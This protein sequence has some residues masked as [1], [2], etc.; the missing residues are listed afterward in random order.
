MDTAELSA[1][2]SFARRFVRALALGVVHLD[3]RAS[4]DAA[5]A[6]VVCR[7]SAALRGVQFRRCFVTPQI[8]CCR[9]ASSFGVAQVTS[10]PFCAQDARA[11]AEIAPLRLAQLRSCAR[12]VSAESAFST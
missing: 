9:R 11:R 1:I 12:P 5:S 10:A 2:A 8:G 6:R 7:F 3:R 4:S